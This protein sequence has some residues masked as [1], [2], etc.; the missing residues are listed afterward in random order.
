MYRPWNPTKAEIERWLRTKELK[1]SQKEN[2]NPKYTPHKYLDIY[3]FSELHEV[4]FSEFPHLLQE[5][6]LRLKE[7]HPMN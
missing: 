7:N 2:R 1:F 5:S 3:V 4:F 6:L